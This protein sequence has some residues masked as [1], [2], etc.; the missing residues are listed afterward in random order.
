MPKLNF[1][2][3][4]SLNYEIK[5]VINVPSIHTYPP[6]HHLVLFLKML[7]NFK[8]YP[9]KQLLYALMLPSGNDAA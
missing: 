5:T 4:L 2:E 9:I 7:I 1:W 6:I 3:T 8:R